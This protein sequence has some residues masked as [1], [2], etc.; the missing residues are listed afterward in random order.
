[1][2]IE[3]DEKKFVEEKNVKCEACQKIIKDEKIHFQK[4][5]LCQ[6]WINKTA[7]CSIARYLQNK[8]SLQEKN[9]I[10]NDYKCISCEKVFS[11]IGNLNKHLKNHLVCK[12]IIEY[13]E[14]KKI[15]DC[16]I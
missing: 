10:L 3:K 5:P 4:N 13:E 9:I 14:L 2:E 8:H 12:K 16:L 7:S 11:N 1:M 6:T 15:N